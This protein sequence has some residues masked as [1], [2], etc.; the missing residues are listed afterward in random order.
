MNGNG[1][2]E[3]CEGQ[4]EENEYCPGG[5][6][7]YTP[8]G[9]GVETCPEGY[10]AGGNTQAECYKECPDHATDP[11]NY[12]KAE[13]SKVYYPADTNSC[14]Y[15]WIGE[16]DDPNDET[17]GHITYII[18]LNGVESNITDIL[19]ISYTKYTVGDSVA[20]PSSEVINSIDGYA[21][22]YEFNGTWYYGSNFRS[23]VSN[24]VRLS[25]RTLTVYGKLSSKNITCE[26]GQRLNGNGEC[27]DCEGQIEENEY[28]PGG[29]ISYMLRFGF[30]PSKIFRIA[31]S[32]FENAYSK[33]VI[34]KWL[35]TFYRRFFAQ[36]FKRSCLPDGPKVGTV[37]LSPRGDWRMPSDASVNIWLKELG[38]I[39]IED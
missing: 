33:P 27:E 37:T 3:D 19:D 34:M 8:N 32:A 30:S 12:A 16:G 6:I 20:L 29:D 5:D 28:C 9:G 39:A 18:V 24:P 11:V 7:P 10:I 15:V 1:E 14:K 17:I 38:Q 26:A 22:K 25:Q 35:K 23:S 2:C 4:I 21:G 36:Q 13:P 31:C